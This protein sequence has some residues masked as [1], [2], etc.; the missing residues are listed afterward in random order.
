MSRHSKKNCFNE[1]GNPLEMKELAKLILSALQKGG[2]GVQDPLEDYGQQLRVRIAKEEKL[3]IQRFIRGYRSLLD[4]IQS[5][6][7]SS[8]EP[9]A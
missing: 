4:Q 8:A 5:G 6:K 9:E 1:M 3:F 7:N 2:Q